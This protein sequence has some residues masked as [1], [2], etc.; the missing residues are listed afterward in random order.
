EH[1]GR[2]AVLL[3]LPPFG[4]VFVV[5]RPS[6]KP[7]DAVVAFQCDSTNAWLPERPPAKR[8]EIKR[9]I[10]GVLSDPSKCVDVTKQL[11]AMVKGGQLVVQ[12]SNAIAGDPAPF[13]V[14]QL[15]VDYTLDGEERTEIVSEGEVLEIPKG[16]GLLAHF[17]ADL[18]VNDKGQME[19]VAWQN[20]VYTI[21]TRAGKRRTINVKSVPEPLA[22]D[23]N[24]EVRFPPNWGAPEVV[25]FERLIS[26]SQHPDAGVRYFSGTA[27]YLQEFE[28]PKDWLSREKVIV[29]DLGVVRHIAEVRLN[30][31]S[32]GVK[33]KPPF[34][35]D[36]TK[37]VKVGKNRLEV[38]VTNNWVNRLIGDEDLPDD[39][40][41]REDGGLRAFPQWFVEG[42]QRPSGRLTFTTWK[43]YRKG[44][45][46]EEAGLLGP[47]RLIFGT[48]WSP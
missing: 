41:W 30:G 27:T 21:Q 6:A 36:I 1:N 23:N 8:L 24:W 14:K 32:L 38:I 18:Q 17:P 46:L 11:Q 34:R 29:L 12:A 26:W 7:V 35:W 37:F 43:Y 40:E 15:R 13:I 22:L 47:V 25:K 9:A 20:G 16:A 28:V 48:C 44:S 42:K 2:T 3:R 33:W 5:F 45:L 31:V 39:C 19:L 4:S 10:Y